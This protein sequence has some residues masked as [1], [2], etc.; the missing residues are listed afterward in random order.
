[1]ALVSHAPMA[2]DVSS[3]TEDLEAAPT[4]TD[5]YQ[6]LAVDAVRPFRVSLYFI[7]CCLLYYP[8]LC[9]G[10]FTTVRRC[11]Q[12]S[13][14]SNLIPVPPHNRGSPALSDK[15]CDAPFPPGEFGSVRRQRSTLQSKIRRY[16]LGHIAKRGFLAGRAN[17]SESQGGM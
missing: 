11:Q 13:R 16:V 10:C 7:R 14:L 4:T 12:H 5:G 17:R 9:L 3:D 15:A 6:P 8:C 2:T 1:M